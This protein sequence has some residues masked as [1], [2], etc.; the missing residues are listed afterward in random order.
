MISVADKRSSGGLLE[1]WSSAAEEFLIYH[2]FESRKVLLD[3]LPYLI[4]ADLRVSVGQGVAEVTD[5]PPV[6]PGM[7]SL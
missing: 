7:A 1:Q 2:R 6:D 4:Q 3:G 5:P